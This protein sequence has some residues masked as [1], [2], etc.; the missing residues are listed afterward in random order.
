M[1]LASSTTLPKVSHEWDEPGRIWCGRRCISFDRRSA[2]EEKEGRA[3]H[4]TF[5]RRRRVARRELGRLPQHQGAAADDQWRS[6]FAVDLEGLFTSRAIVAVDVD[7]IRVG[8]V[9]AKRAGGRGTENDADG[10]RGHRLDERELGERFAASVDQ[11]GAHHSSG[12][13]SAGG[14]ATLATAG[15]CARAASGHA[16]APPSGVMKSRRFTAGPS[17]AS[18]R[19]DNTTL[20]RGG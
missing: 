6:R 10:I 12:K 14:S 13:I 19:K 9:Q 20:L 8:V 2:R 16:T 11:D 17:R 5:K 15:V 18:G 1:D 3:H 7:K 4:E